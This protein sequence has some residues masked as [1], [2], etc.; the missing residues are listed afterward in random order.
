M[1]TIY[2]QKALH[3]IKY[4]GSTLS[5]KI[6]Y[7]GINKDGFIAY[8]DSD[9]AGDRITRRSTSGNVVMLAGGAVTWVSRKQKTVAQS[10]TE[11]EYISMSDTCRQL[12]WIQSLLGELNMPIKSIDL[13]GDN[14]G[15]IFSASN[16]VQET[17]TKHIDIRYHYICEI[18]NIGKVKLT[19]V[20]M[21]TQIA[22]VLTKNLSFD[23]LKKFREMMGLYFDDT[24]LN[25]NRSSMS[26]KQPTTDELEKFINRLLL[27]IPD[28]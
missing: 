25:L 5:A 27:S 24:H 9:W 19:Y 20:S 2:V 23:K 22:D 17:R 16:P 6:I 15:A 12:V 10:S 18:V 1:K 7:N 14:Q 11:A 26:V 8:A 4:V 13:C 3:I 28:V 21:D